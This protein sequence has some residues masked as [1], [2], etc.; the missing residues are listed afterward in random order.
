[1]PAYLLVEDRYQ[2]YG[3]SCMSMIPASQS[4][5]TFL[6]VHL[7][8]GRPQVVYYS[9]VFPAINQYTH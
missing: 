6:P 5:F 1:L 9:Y 2:V 8:R 4:G 3:L 7:Y